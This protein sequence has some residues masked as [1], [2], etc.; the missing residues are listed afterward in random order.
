MYTKIIH[1]LSLAKAKALWSVHGLKK[2]KEI[3]KKENNTKYSQQ[4]NQEI[5]RTWK[6]TM[7]NIH[8]KKK[9]KKTDRKKIIHV[10]MVCHLVR[11]REIS[12]SRGSREIQNFG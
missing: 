2:M 9:E 6:K 4:K 11:Y 12:I 3:K 10:R 1:F 7:L 8:G 5:Q